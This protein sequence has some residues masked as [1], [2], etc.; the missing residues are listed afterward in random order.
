MKTFIKSMCVVLCSMMF[1]GLA[2]CG[3]D[4]N[5]DGDGNGVTP[6]PS[7]NYSLENL[8][9][10]WNG[11]SSNSTFKLAFGI[12]GNNTF[13]FSLFR[14][15]SSSSNYE[16]IMQEQG[17]YVFDTNTGELKLTYSDNSTEILKVSNQTYSSFTLT[18]GETT[19]YMTR[20]T[21][22]GGD[23]GGGTT[24]D[25]APSNVSD[26]HIHVGLRTYSLDLYF[27]SNT[28]VNMTYSKMTSP[29]NLVRASY[30]K[31]GTNT[32]TISY[33]WD[34][35]TGTVTSTVE[36]TFTSETGGTA[37]GDVMSG[38][39]TIEN[40]A[41]SSDVEA[42]INIANKTLHVPHGTDTWFKF[43]SQNGTR[44]NI[45]DYSSVI[46]Y[47]TIYATYIR[48]SSTSATLT[49][50]MNFSSYTTEKQ[51]TYT[52]DFYTNTSGKYSFHSNNGSYGSSSWT[53]DFTL[54]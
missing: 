45:T 38:T 23:S 8:I 25:Y 21:D 9:G 48:T 28:S 11:I 10:V 5:S 35:T 18:V 16:S 31:S 14:Y 17:T 1:F 12:Y 50:H 22:S 41:R 40:F 15:N 54:E 42:P 20:Y 51:E 30:S 24:V 7:A 52:L 32:A 34:G 4:S 37:K 13:Q 26:K 27:D 49:I 29:F 47:Q 39:F 2:A 33:T 3:G 19:F 43:G 36:L 53:G 46:S 6:P 44:V